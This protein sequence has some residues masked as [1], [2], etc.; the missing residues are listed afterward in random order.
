MIF[1]VM[2]RGIPYFVQRFS[3]QLGAFRWRIDQK[4]SSKNVFEDSYLMLVLPLLQ[5]MSLHMPIPFLKGADYSQFER[6][7]FPQGQAQT[8]LRDDYGI[9]TGSDPHFD[10]GRLLRED[11]HFQDSIDNEGIQVADLINGGLRRCLRGGFSENDSA[12]KL[13]GALMVQD[14]SQ[15]PPLSLVGFGP[16]DGAPADEAAG[17]A[18]ILMKRHC[19]PLLSSTWQPTSPG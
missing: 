2:S 10:L 13:L 7:E 5:T 6:F 8:Y 11:L 17:R 15:Q 12:A 9:Q 4:N 3:Q 1:S 16:G 19:R 14:R 18:V